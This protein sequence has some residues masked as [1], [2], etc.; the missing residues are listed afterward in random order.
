MLAILLRARESRI[1]ANQPA[2][3][4]KPTNTNDDKNLK[5]KSK[6]EKY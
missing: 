5:K 4:E 6:E 2:I 3:K 1:D